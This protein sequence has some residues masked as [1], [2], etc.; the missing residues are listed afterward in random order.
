MNYPDDTIAAISTPVGQGG[1]GIVRLSGPDAVAIAEG[2]FCSKNN[3]RPSDAPSHKMLYGHIV[4]PD[5][6]HVVDEVLLAVMHAP[7]SYTRE[8]VVEINC[9]GSMLSVRQIL[10]LA[11]RQ[12]VRVAEP[13]EFTKRAFL[14]GR[15]DL[16]QAEAVLDI[17]NA[18]TEES[19]RIASEQLRGGLT[20]KLSAIREQLIEITAFVEAHID[21]PE[22]EIE[23][24]S[25][26]EIERKLSDTTAEILKLSDTFN[27]A[28]F[29]REGL[30]IAIVGRPNVGKSSLL[31]ALLQKDRAIV[32]DLPGT[33]R[34][35]I[36]DYLNIHGLPVRIMDTAGIRSSDQIVEQEGIRRSMQAIEHADFIV[37]L[38]DGSEPFGQE[39]HDLL[40]LIRD[41]NALMVISKADLPQKISFENS[42]AEGKGSL[43]ISA[44]TGEGIERLKS[45]IFES[46][47]RGWQEEREGVVITNIRHKAAL[48]G[49]AESL[50]RAGVLLSGDDP[51]ELFSIEMRGSLDR[52]GEITGTIT[53]DEIL[54]KIFNSFCIGK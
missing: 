13:G 11:L 7:N 35:L 31:N 39:D 17:I 14:H 38:F 44:V 27:E 22:D 2:I 52:I 45:V 53:T 5:D 6:E 29:F 15:I 20:E 43:C 23:A 9:H 40:A 25:K 33:T 19:M 18:K 30:S 37:A 54:M 21:F 24:T 47:L 50:N 28:R 26:N 41:K 12:G 34:D 1:I 4:D 48:D 10:E 32:T 16:S 42:A 3:E 49:A 51:L 36:E 46:N 8:D